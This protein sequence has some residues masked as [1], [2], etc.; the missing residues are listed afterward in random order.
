VSDSPPQ[1]PSPDPTPTPEP[2]RR[3][4]WQIGLRTFSLFIV[5]IAVWMTDIANRREN[6]RIEAGIET[7]LPIARELA[8]TDPTQITAVKRQESWYD[9]NIWDLHLPKGQFRLCLATREIAPSSS[10]LPPV[11]RSRPLSPGKHTVALELDKTDDL[12]R[13]SVSIDQ[14]E[15]LEVEEPKEWNEGVG[16]SGGSQIS[17]SRPFPP[18]K[19]VVLFHRR[20][21]RQTKNSSSGLQTSRTPSGP[22][23][24]LMIWIEPVP[25]SLK[26]KE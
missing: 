2:P 22:S 20:F 14:D 26:P 4:R 10:V 12:W 1:D 18:D 15:S 9:E 5:A 11:V 13:V 24:G 17:E 23:E 25:T 21:S 8:I 3:S 6:E 19:P 16:S 7:M